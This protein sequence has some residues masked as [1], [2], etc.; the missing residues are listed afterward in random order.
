MNSKNI[1]DLQTRSKTVRRHLKLN[2]QAME[3]YDIRS[4]FVKQCFRRRKFF[5][6]NLK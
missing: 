1:E 2:Q 6:K 5:K 3:S 4:I